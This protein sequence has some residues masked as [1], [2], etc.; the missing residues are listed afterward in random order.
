MPLDPASRLMLVVFAFGIETAQRD[1]LST[2]WECHENTDKHAYIYPS[3]GLYNRRQSRATP[4]SR[5][6]RNCGARA[7]ENDECA[8]EGKKDMWNL[9]NAE[10]N[11]VQGG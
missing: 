9:L 11:R 7:E 10:R 8:D 6:L 2:L 4:E 3:R 5:Q 1:I